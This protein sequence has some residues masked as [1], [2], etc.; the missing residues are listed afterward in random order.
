MKRNW[1]FP[2]VGIT[3]LASLVF[4]TLMVSCRLF[5]LSVSPD[6]AKGILYTMMGVSGSIIG[7]LVIYLSLALEGMKRNYGKQA[8]AYFR[9]DRVVWLLCWVFCFV[10]LISLSS[11]C[12]ADQRGYFWTWSFNV[13]CLSFATGIALIV[14]FGQVILCSR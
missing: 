4:L 10:I 3:Y 1:L 7:F 12:Y 6:T 5:W 14:P 13:A 11:C 9:Q 8:I 2:A